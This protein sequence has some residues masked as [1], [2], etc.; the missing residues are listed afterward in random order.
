MSNFFVMAFFF[1]IPS[2]VILFLL[3]APTFFVVIRQKQSKY[4]RS[5]IYAYALPLELLVATS[6]S[7]LANWVGLLN[8]VGIVFAAAFATG[9]L[10]AIAAHHF[11]RIAN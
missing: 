11:S 4:P 7:F 2:I 10:G 5:L 6:L 9:I 1:A 8:P 3:W